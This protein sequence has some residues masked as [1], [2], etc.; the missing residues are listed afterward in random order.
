MGFY[1]AVALRPASLATDRSMRNKIRKGKYVDVFTLTD[2]MLKE[3][4]KAKKGGR[5]RGGHFS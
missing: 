1:D 5:V 4:E 2:D 3:Y